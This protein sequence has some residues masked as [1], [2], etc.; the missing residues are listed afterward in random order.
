[1]AMGGHNFVKIHQKVTILC[2]NIVVYA[3][4]V[5]LAIW[6][7]KKTLDLVRFLVINF[8]ISLEFLFY[9]S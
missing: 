1:M 3:S 8:K 7:L 2:V 9:I 4:V 5:K 6:L